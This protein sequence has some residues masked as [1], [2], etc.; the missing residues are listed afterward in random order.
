MTYMAPHADSD[1]AVADLGLVLYHGTST[2]IMRLDPSRTV[3]GG[4]H[5]G[6]RAQA[7]MRVGGRG[8][9]LQAR[10]IIDPLRVRRSRDTGGNWKARIHQARAA[11]CQAIVYLNRYEGIPTERVLD[12]QSQGVDLDRLTDAQ[13]RQ[14]VPEAQDS[15]IVFSLEQVRVLDRIEPAAHA[16]VDASIQPSASVGPPVL[17]SPSKS[18]RSMRSPR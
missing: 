13:F 14:Q 12:A 15:W 5:F 18:T 8:C 10:L 7:R 2:S 3:D 11:G 9:L 16:Q 17:T 4:L 1:N 6:T